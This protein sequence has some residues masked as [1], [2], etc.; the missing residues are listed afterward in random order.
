MYEEI[1]GQYHLEYPS[2]QFRLST[3]T[4]VLADFCR[5]SR[6]KR[7]CDLGCGC[8]ALSLLL[9]AAYPDAHVTGV[10]LQHD[11]AQY[12][13]ENAARN[14]LLQRLT[15]LEGDLREY[16]ALL[17]HGG[18]DAVAANPPYYPLS[19]GKT[20][21]EPALAD[22]R[23]ENTC[24]LDALCRCAAWALKFGGRFCLVHKPE[25]LTDLLVS[26]RQ[27][28]LEPKR[29]RFVRHRPDAPISLVLIESRLGGKCGL[30]IEP[31]LILYQSDGT[32]SADYLRIYHQEA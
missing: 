8:G 19:G 24:T 21:A 7:I 6:A 3:D 12:A 9:C 31:D 15:I 22:A 28:A 11:A 5:F 32:P 14:A 25:R 10:E 1:C 20:A 29:L 23:S 27:N 4:M 17:P 18:F 16:R 30:Q 13:R 26:L 2:G